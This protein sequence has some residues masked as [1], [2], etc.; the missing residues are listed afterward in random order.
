[1]C[2]HPQDNKMMQ[3]EEKRKDNSRIIESQVTETKQSSGVKKKNKETKVQLQQAIATLGSR[4][5]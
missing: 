5:K 1:M 4:M 2:L 3:T